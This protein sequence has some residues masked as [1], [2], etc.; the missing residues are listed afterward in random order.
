MNESEIYK[1]TNERLNGRAVLNTMW[2]VRSNC[3]YLFTYS[4]KSFSLGIYYRF[5][6][7]LGK[8]MSEPYIPDPDALFSA[9]DRIEKNFDDNALNYFGCVDF[10]LIGCILK[11]DMQRPDLVLYNFPSSWLSDI[12]SFRKV[13]YNFAKNFNKCNYQ[14]K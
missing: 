3:I 7:K 2:P 12:H 14:V 4:C 1:L 6:V 9:L 5:D 8:T 13:Y 10:T 11:R